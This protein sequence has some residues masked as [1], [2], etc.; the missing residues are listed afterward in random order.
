MSGHWVQSTACVAV[1]ERSP[2][3]GP[4][5]QRQLSPSR[6][7]VLESR[8][9]ENLVTLT[10]KFSESVIVLDLDSA[11]EECL[12]WLENQFKRPN[13]PAVIACA[14]HDLF[15]LEWTV[16][17]AGVIAYV[18]DEISGRDLARVCLR[19]IKTK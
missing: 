15:Q 6:V 8:S 1:Y 10:E 7:L 2:R 17:E 18:N 4:E 19:Q 14:S 11:P 5:L 3:L 12:A 9:L 13:K 16:R